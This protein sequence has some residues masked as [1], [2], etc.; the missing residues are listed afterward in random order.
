MTCRRLT[1]VTL[2]VPET[3]HRC[4]TSHCMDLSITIQTLQC[5]L[6]C[7][8]II[9]SHL[10]SPQHPPNQ[11]CPSSCDWKELDCV[12]SKLWCMHGVDMKRCM[13][14]CSYL[15]TGEQDCADV[16]E[17]DVFPKIKPTPRSCS[18][19]I[20]PSFWSISCDGEREEPSVVRHQ[21]HARDR[22]DGCWSPWSC[23]S[24]A[25]LMFCSSSFAESGSESILACF[26]LCNGLNDPYNTNFLSTQLHWVVAGC[27]QGAS[28]FLHFEHV[29]FSSDINASSPTMEALTNVT[30]CLTH[31][32]AMAH[33]NHACEES[34]LILSGC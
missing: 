32:Q 24:S 25:L 23:N 12:Q 15:R 6:Q 2:H 27:V 10:T 9:S 19:R 4:R 7:V 20:P 11:F 26:V 34:S 22:C 13:W 21:S 17:D 16:N 14:D 31:T 28:Y 29:N 1:L 18:C 8:F 5:T 33:G 30:P 3:L